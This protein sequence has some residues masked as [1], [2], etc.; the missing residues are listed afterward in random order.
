MHGGSLD[1]LLLGRH[2]VFAD[3]QLASRP[4]MHLLPDK[5]SI[6]KHGAGVRNPVGAGSRAVAIEA[7]G[8]QG[9]AVYWWVSVD[10]GGCGVGT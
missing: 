7:R 5:V 3:R 10:Q 2:M 1:I 4:A 9:A 6:A 8:C